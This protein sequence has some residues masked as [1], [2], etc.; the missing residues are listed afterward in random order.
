MAVGWEPALRERD[1]DP[2]VLA[3]HL[4][5]GLM[6]TR[7][8]TTR[9][10][11]PGVRRPG[12]GTPAADRLDQPLESVGRGAVRAG[13]VL[14]LQHVLGNQAVQRLLTTG[15][16]GGTIQ[17]SEGRPQGAVI[18]RL[19]VKLIAGLDADKPA[20]YDTGGGHSYADHGAHTTEEQQRQRLRTG[21]A[22]SGRS[23]PVPRDS[24]ASKFASDAKH[25]EGMQAAVAE[26]KDKNK[27]K[28]KLKGIT[29]PMPL[30][31][32]G[33]VYYRDGS[34]IIGKTVSVDLTKVAGSDDTF[35]LNTMF[36]MP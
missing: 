7:Q 36:P 15:S 6:Q 22:P 1:G 3:S 35:R 14:G 19:V 16:P 21:I 33:P 20:T 29:G 25:V 27:G 13:D 26:L 34:T 4:S 30:D 31:G 18:Q 9:T 28:G 11:S 2:A 23:S 24:G 5:R 32:A 17:R 10:R 12:Q 8:R